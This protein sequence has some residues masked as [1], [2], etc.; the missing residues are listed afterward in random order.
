[1]EIKLLQNRAERKT[2]ELSWNTLT[3]AKNY[4]KNYYRPSTHEEYR[5]VQKAP[6][7]T[8]GGR[9]WVLKEPA[10]EAIK[11][12]L[13][14]VHNDPAVRTIISQSTIDSPIFDELER[15]LYNRSG[16]PKDKR[17]F[18]EILELLEDTLNMQ[19]SEFEF[20]FP[21][22]GVALE[23]VNTV[24]HGAV[25]LFVCNQVTCKQL[26][27]DFLEQSPSWEPEELTLLS[28]RFDRDFL[29]RVIIKSVALGDDSIARNKAYRQARE[30]I[31]YLRFFICFLIHER[32]TEQIIRVNL[33]VEAYKG[34]EPFL[35]KK[36]SS[37]QVALHEGRGQSYLE[38][39]IIDKSRLEQLSRPGFLNDF[40]SITKNSLPTEL[41]SIILTAI[42]W[43]GE[44]QNEFNLDV[45]FVKYWTALE[46]IFTEWGKPT[47]AV[48]QGVS[49]LNAYSHCKFIDTAEIKDVETNVGKLYDKR[50]DIIH[51]GMRHIEEE[52]RGIQASDV[53]Q[54]CKYAAWS[55]FSLFELRSLRYTT[56]SQVTERLD[57]VYS[58]S[59]SEDL[60]D[61]AR[62]LEHDYEVEQP[63]RCFHLISY[64]WRH[65]LKNHKQQ[66]NFMNVP[67]TFPQQGL[68]RFNCPSCKA[69]S[70]QIWVSPRM[71][72]PTI[73]SLLKQGEDKNFQVCKCC[74]C[75]KNSIWYSGKMIYPECS[76]APFPDSDLP[77]E[78]Y[79]D[80]EE[81]RTIVDR[82]P[83]GAAAL[84]RLVI[85]KLCVSLGKPGR[86]LNS[87]IASL[88][89]DGLPVPVQQA[90][91]VV[92]V[93]GN[94]AVHPGQINL[95]DNR[96]T[97][98]K[99]F[100]LVNL[101][102]QRMITQPKEIKALFDGLP[103]GATEGINA[104]DRDTSAS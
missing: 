1:M 93:I 73:D 67:Y 11:A 62:R 28:E 33:S 64:K 71:N 5:E 17:D 18:S 2:A 25:E 50:S 66:R 96:E 15:E 91:D 89:K 59:F 10:K 42:H 9:W 29:D 101:I 69:F 65:I 13:N 31:N 47:K 83:R 68:S 20:F 21:I 52:G 43:I 48:T 49:K 16:N 74:H 60:I 24:G 87:D 88:V 6:K 7:L 32:I 35:S 104:R 81:A 54:L 58:P 14:S 30:F 55:I 86:N 38:K 27:S 82:S 79:V 56:R 39:F 85:Q 72:F 34:R 46:C 102:V 51:R 57:A 44:A 92:R 98:N 22:E 80:Y 8:V 90:L 40:I 103:D 77:A 3:N 4:H 94:N 12:L 75:D 63:L 45:A 37:N 41:E 26:L 70:T 19:V 99:L 76:A 61:A 53:S 95:K 100:T 23:G 97:A 78:L 36:Q 84:L